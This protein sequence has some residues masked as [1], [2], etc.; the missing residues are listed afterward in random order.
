MT[1]WIGLWY[2][3]LVSRNEGRVKIKIVHL[4]QIYKF[5]FDYFLEKRT[6]FILINKTL[7]KIKS[8]VIKN[9]KFNFIGKYVKARKTACFSA[10]ILTFKRTRREF[11]KSKHSFAVFLNQTYSLESLTAYRI[12]RLK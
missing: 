2:T 6:V 7:L 11:V 3:F 8:C 12:I 9:Q 5:Y 10:T 1:D 4:K